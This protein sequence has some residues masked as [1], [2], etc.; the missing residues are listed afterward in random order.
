MI[1]QL[2]K[3]QFEK[4][5]RRQIKMG[6]KETLVDAILEM[7]NNRQI[8]LIK[9]I[10]KWAENYHI[11]KA[12]CGYDNEEEKGFQKGLTAGEKLMQKDLTQF[13]DSLIRNNK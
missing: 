5:L 1:D 2:K 6:G 7:T 12:D 13:L 3:S 8:A 4:E 10:K 9:E 11:F